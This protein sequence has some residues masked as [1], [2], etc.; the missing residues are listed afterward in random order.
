MRPQTFLRCDRCRCSNATRYFIH[1][2]EDGKEDVDLCM[3]CVV[4]MGGCLLN[5]VPDEEKQNWLKAFL[6]G[7]IR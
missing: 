1:V 3:N 2:S 4:A 5:R 7:I 6:Q